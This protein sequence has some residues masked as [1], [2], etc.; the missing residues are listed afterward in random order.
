MHKKLSLFT[1]LSRTFD[2]FE[3]VESGH[4]DAACA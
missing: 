2:L 3:L 1:E 4:K